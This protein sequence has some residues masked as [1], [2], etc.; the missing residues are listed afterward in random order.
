MCRS[1]SRSSNKFARVADCSPDSSSPTKPG[2][3]LVFADRDRLTEVLANLLDNADKY[4]PPGKEVAIDIRA[5][6]IEVIVSV[7][8]RGRG[9]PPNDLDHV[10]D[11]FYRADSSDAQTAY[12]Y[13]WAC[14]SA[15]RL[16]QAQ[17]GRIWAENAPD[18]R[19]C[20]FVCLAGD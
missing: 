13:G 18:G 8:D 19:R 1:C 12:G 15:A 5:D 11:K 10:F 6:Q 4:S 17:G 16:V 20:F 3:P 9:L 2:L 7:R 14:T